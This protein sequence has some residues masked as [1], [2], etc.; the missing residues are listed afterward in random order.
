METPEKPLVVIPPLTSRT[1]AGE[2]YARHEAVETELLSVL[3][4]GPEEWI[5]RRTGLQSESLV[6]LNRYI[7]RKDDYAAGRLQQE[8]N[9]RTVRMAKRWIYGILRRRHI[10]HR[11]G[12]RR[13]NHG[14]SA[15]RNTVAPERVS[16]R[17]RIRPNGYRRT[18]NA[19]ENV[20]KIRRSPTRATSCQKAMTK[21]EGMNS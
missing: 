3:L 16:S 8:I 20:S 18:K 10:I 4:H 12:R 19:V 13:G 9:A 5:K 17:G 11:V 21:M 2:L 15:G 7:R 14:A 6:F 1:D